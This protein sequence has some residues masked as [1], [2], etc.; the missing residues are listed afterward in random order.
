ML[1]DEDKVERLLQ[2]LEVKLKSIPKIGGALSEVPIMASLV[3]SYIRKEY[4]D[5]PIGT[6]VAIISALLYFVSPIDIIPDTIPG[7]GHVDDALV[8]AVCLKLVD[9]DIQEYV[10]W[11]QNNG[12][13]IDVCY[14]VEDS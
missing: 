6:V 4:P 7:L 1:E 3:R 14:A 9:S 13:K 5:L 2:R 12:K 10:K 8:V 11:R